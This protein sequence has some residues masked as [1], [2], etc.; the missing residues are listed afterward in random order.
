LHAA[1]LIARLLLAAVFVVAALAKLA[2]RAGSRQAAAGFGV[3]EALVPAFALALPLAELAVAAALLPVASARFGAVGALALLTAFAGAI[4]RSMIRGEAPDCHCFGQLHSAPAG[5]RTLIRNVGLAGAAVFVVAG[6][7]HDPGPSAV[8]WIAGLDPAGTVALAGGAAL[9]LLAGAGAAFM[10]ALL[11][12]QGRLLLRI[13]EL[14]TRLDQAGVAAAPRPPEQPEHGLPVGRPAP[15]FR[16]TGL[17]GETVTLEALTA[18]DKPI[19]LVFT[20]PGCGPCNA[21]LAPIAQWQRDLATALTIAVVTRGTADD[22]RAKIREHGIAGVWLDP[23]LAV[24]N[25]YQAPATPAAVLVDRD[26]RIATPAVA[27]ADAIGALV[28]KATGKVHVLQPAPRAPAQPQPLHVGAEAPPVE[29]P[30][31][32]GQLVSFAYEERDTLVLFWNPGCGFCQRMVDDLRGWEAAPPAGAP[33][34][35][36]IS[37]GSVH[38]NEE[39]RLRAPILLDQAF[40]TGTKFGTTATPSGILVDANGRI[41]SQLAIGAPGV[42]TLAGGSPQPVRRQT[43]V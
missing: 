17:Y 23:D 11:R 37:S 18:V 41:A 2:D 20:D 42:M 9:A 13:D 24:F 40:A 33:R 31:L 14:E 27:G 3:P 12:Q 43:R 29:L 32:G 26:G 8:T 35:L 30:D 5:W 10:L 39:L 28:A 7:W 25:A 19:M 16:L 15:D 38:D 21:L 6:G 22:N 34:L 36:L 4:A 1:L